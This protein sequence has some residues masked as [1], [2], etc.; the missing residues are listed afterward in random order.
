MRVDVR[1]DGE[2]VVHSRDPELVAEVKRVVQG[3]LDG[4][5]EYEEIEIAD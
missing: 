1:E 4:T 5:V 2:I 3:L